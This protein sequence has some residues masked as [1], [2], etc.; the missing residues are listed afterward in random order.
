[1]STDELTKL[2]DAA[3]RDVPYGHRCPREYRA[4]DHRDRAVD[5]SDARRQSPSL[6]HVRLE[7]VVIISAMQRLCGK[8]DALAKKED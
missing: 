8:L 1:M 4:G 6:D 5:H 7:A 3:F 2:I